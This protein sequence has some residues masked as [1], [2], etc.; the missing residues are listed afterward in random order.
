MNLIEFNAALGGMN[1]VSII[2]G[3]VKRMRFIDYVKVTKVNGNFVDGQRGDIIL[4]NMEVLSIGGNGYAINITPKVGD[5]VMAFSSRTYIKD[6]KDFKQDTGV[7]S[8]CNSTLKCIPI[9]SVDNAES[10]IIIDENG[11][12]FTD[13]NDNSITV[14]SDGIN[15]ADGN[16]N[17]I[18]MSSD[19][20]VINGKLTISN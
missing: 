4:T 8:Y 16:N 3:I 13:A 11:F 18:T 1:G 10:T 2:Q 15:L 20:T 19:G 17:T 14:N 5:I 12:S 9:T 7:D 6:M